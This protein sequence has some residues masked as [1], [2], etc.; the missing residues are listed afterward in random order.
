MWESRWDANYVTLQGE[1]DAMSA[2]IVTFDATRLTASEKRLSRLGDVRHSVDHS[3]S[4]SDDRPSEYLQ[5]QT[6]QVQVA[7][8]ISAA[9]VTFVLDKESQEL[10]IQVIDRETGEV[11][12]EIPPVEMRRLAASF[13][14]TFGHLF[15]LFA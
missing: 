2:D 14:E 5:S 11:L 10:Y 12:R 7:D 13:K 8:Q 3:K 1:S 4:K 6:R 15:D 9:T